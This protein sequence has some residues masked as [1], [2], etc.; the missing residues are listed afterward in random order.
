MQKLIH[1]F[2]IPLWITIFTSCSLQRMVSVSTKYPPTEEITIIQTGQTLP[3]GVIRMGSVS[4]G[5]G[6]LTPTEDCTYEA[7]M[8]AVKEEAQRVG[9]DIVYIVQVTTPN[10]FVGVGYSFWGGSTYMGGGSTCYGIVAD[11][12]KQQD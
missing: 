12:Y 4:V 2:L 6:G 10:A 9:A 3:N 11:L 1:I 8:Q 5:D 7:C